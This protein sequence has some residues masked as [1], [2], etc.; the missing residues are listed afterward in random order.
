MSEMSAWLTVDDRPPVYDL[1][2][3]LGIELTMW[4]KGNETVTLSAPPDESV[5]VGV[6]I[7]NQPP[8]ADTITEGDTE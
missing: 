6:G 4:R 1:G 7:G 5:G 2:A 8:Q 3:T